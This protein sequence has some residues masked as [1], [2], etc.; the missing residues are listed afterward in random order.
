LVERYS[1]HI[2]AARIKK[3]AQFLTKLIEFHAKAAKNIAE[4]FGR[5]HTSL[6]L[7]TPILKMGWR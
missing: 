7:C 3:A 5:K 1:N 2:F 6:Y 4:N